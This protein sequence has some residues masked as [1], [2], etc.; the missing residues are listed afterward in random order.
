MCSLWL[1]VG[2]S[3]VVPHGTRPWVPWAICHSTRS[4]NAFSSI[5]PCRNGVMRA[6]IE[7]VN[8]TLASEGLTQ[9]EH[10]AGPAALQGNPG[11]PATPGNPRVSALI[12]TPPP[13]FDKF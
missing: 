4:W 13:I 3:P 1:S 10:N 7:P 9:A 2:D 8:M 5:L 11:R 12:K 6:T